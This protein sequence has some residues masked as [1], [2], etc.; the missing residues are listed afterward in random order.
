M[1]IKLDWDRLENRN[2]EIAN[3]KKNA[4]KKNKIRFQQKKIGNSLKYIL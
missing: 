1:K 4:A 2:K 3:L